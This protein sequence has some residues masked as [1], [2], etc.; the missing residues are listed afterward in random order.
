MDFGEHRDAELA[1]RRLQ[2]RQPIVVERSD[3]EQDAIRAERARL[4]DLVLVD[5]EILAQHGQGACLTRCREMLGCALEIVSVGQHGEARRPA[6]FVATRDSCRIED[7]PEHATAR[8]RLLDLRNDAR[9]AGFDPVA[10]CTHKIA[11][12]WRC[13]CFLAQRGKRP[14]CARGSNFLGLGGEDPGEDVAVGRPCR[15]HDPV[16]YRPSFWV[17]ATNASSFFLAAPEAIDSRARAM[18][19]AID[20]A[21]PAA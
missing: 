1:S 3:D 15:S 11:H 16:S 2:G 8:A 6:R 12:R 4:G 9:R 10:Q 18:P 17:V 19:S 13:P 5:D 21:S 7:R 14:H 20:T